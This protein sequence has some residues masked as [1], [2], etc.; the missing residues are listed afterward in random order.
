[1]GTIPQAFKIIF[2]MQKKMSNEKI[3]SRKISFS[4]YKMCFFFPSF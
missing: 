3:T 1:M 2:E 4:L